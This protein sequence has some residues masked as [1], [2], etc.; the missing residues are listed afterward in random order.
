MIRFALIQAFLCRT[1]RFRSSWKKLTILK[2]RGETAKDITT[3]NPTKTDLARIYNDYETKLEDGW[4]DEPGRHLYLANNFE[5]AFMQSAFPRVDLVVVEGFTVLSEANIKILTRIAGMRNI[6][7]W[8][9]TDSVPENEALY[10][11]INGLVSTIY[12][13]ERHHRS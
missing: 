11:N 13:S 8:F 12:R 1:A 9:R 7:M 2:E 6:K 5:P 10:K 4:I 3:D